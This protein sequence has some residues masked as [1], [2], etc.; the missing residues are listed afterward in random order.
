M[1]IQNSPSVNSLRI[2]IAHQQ[3]HDN[4][5]W[6]V[7]CPDHGLANWTEPLAIL[8]QPLRHILSVIRKCTLEIIEEAF[9]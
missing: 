2:S 9:K 5:S 7:F 4:A 8:I 3:F 6:V 1:W